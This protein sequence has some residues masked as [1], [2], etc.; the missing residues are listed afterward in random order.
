MHACVATQVLNNRRTSVT[1]GP[2]ARCHVHCHAAAVDSCKEVKLQLRDKLRRVPRLPYEVPEAPQQQELHDLIERLEGANPT[3]DLRNCQDKLA[4]CWAMLYTT[5]TQPDEVRAAL[6]PLQPHAV[7][8][9]IDIWQ[10]GVVKSVEFTEDGKHA[11]PGSLNLGSDFDW[12][13]SSRLALQGKGAAISSD[14]LRQRLPEDQSVFAAAFA[15]VGQ[16][17]YTFVDDGLFIN[18]DEKHV[19]IFEHRTTRVHA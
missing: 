2:N 17:E 3:H 5:R 12:V 4:G 15:P 9:T 8:V 13:A 10:N 19:Y 6:A 11:L 16:M 1:R 18:R 14:E 7:Y